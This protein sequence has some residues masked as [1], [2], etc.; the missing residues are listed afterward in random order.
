MDSTLNSQDAAGR[1]GGVIPSM[2]ICIEC[3]TRYVFSI[4][5]SFLRTLSLYCSIP[6]IDADKDE[7]ADIH[8]KFK[9]DMENELCPK[10]SAHSDAICPGT[11]GHAVLLDDAAPG[12]SNGS[13]SRKCMVIGQFTF[14][15]LFR[16]SALYV[17]IGFK[18][19][20]ECNIQIYY[21]STWL[22]YQWVLKQCMHVGWAYGHTYVHQ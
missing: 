2:N 6:G 3:S 22:L 1:E 7:L 5:F 21:S 4:S 12:K 18:C 20:V 17:C 19:N 15:S 8:D 14:T 10:A 11:I 16:L 13:G 9:A